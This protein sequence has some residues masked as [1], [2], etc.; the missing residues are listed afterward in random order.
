MKLP[1]DPRRVF[2]IVVGV[3]QYAGGWPLHGP[4]MDALSMADWL[5][6]AG[7]P[8][9]QVRVFHNVAS[10][11]AAP[12]NESRNRMLAKIQARGAVLAG[13]PTRAALEATLFTDGLI[14]LG[15]PAGSVLWL[16]WS[17]HGVQTD[18]RRLRH[19]LTSD[20]SA[21]A[22]ATINLTDLGDL[23][24][25]T[26]QLAH[27]T[28]QV[29]IA[30]ACSTWSSGS[31][32]PMAVSHNLSKLSA[33]DVCQERLYASADGQRAT[34]GQGEALSLLSGHLLRLLEGTPLPSLDLDDLWSRLKDAVE[35]AGQPCIIDRL[36]PDGQS[37]Q[38]IGGRPQAQQQRLAALEAIV[39]VRGLWLL[40]PLQRLYRL[41]THCDDGA[42]APASV[43]DIIWQLDEM[44]PR[45][46]ALSNSA[47]YALR[48][49]FE[50]QAMQ[51]EP[52]VPAPRQAQLTQCGVSLDDWLNGCDPA[53]LAQD[54][55]L[56]RAQLTRPSTLFVDLGPETT[57]SWIRLNGEW[58][59][60]AAEAASGDD[61]SRLQAAWQAAVM[62]SLP[63]R[64]CHLE[65]AVDI[66]ALDRLPLG[67]N[68]DAAAAWRPRRIGLE[69]PLSLRLRQR[70]FEHE[71]TINWRQAYEQ[72]SV[73]LDGNAVVDW[74]DERQQADR[75]RLASANA[76]LG[77][78]D[79][80]AP[81]WL[82]CLRGHLWDGS[83]WAI[84]CLPAAS[85]AERQ[86]IAQRAGA[87]SLRAWMQVAREMA[88]LSG[89][90]PAQVVVLADAPDTLPPGCA[91]TFQIP[92]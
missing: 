91:D 70:W 30:D 2:A 25:L 13:E 19:L 67:R 89:Q 54:R 21:N 58:E 85:P 6:T 52:G 18:A 36:A 73:L 3:E 33:Q 88:A 68:L 79:L 37:G 51:G 16:F 20:A 5:L 49:Q 60:V 4:A 78:H 59:F 82:D 41:A 22:L 43:H 26:P 77:I 50:A 15:A 31:W 28:Q 86:L 9:A 47:W 45:A 38:A 64:E 92:L 12:I 87:H 74:L 53:A 23:L 39:G 81:G 32:E 14:T 44:T 62:K 65:L 61:T 24:R 11:A 63:T 90:G 83:L 66:N 17:G 71:L 55:A 72:S 29:L 1:E 57:R 69:L 48:L 8:P 42:P 34:I 27:F 56:L 35:Q 10:G 7:V 40:G 75:N 46:G 84:A 76:W 80:S